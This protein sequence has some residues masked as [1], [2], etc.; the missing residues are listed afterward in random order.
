[1]WVLSCLISLNISRPFAFIH[2]ETSVPTKWRL[3]NVRK[4]WTSEVLRN[5]EH[6]D[7][8]VRQIVPQKERPTGEVQIKIMFPF[9][10][11]RFMVTYSSFGTC[12][13][14]IVLM[15]CRHRN[16][17]YSTFKTCVPKKE[18]DLYLH[19]SSNMNSLTDCQI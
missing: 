16:T 14:E 12:T 15:L 9:R 19:F 18:H 8:T 7:L 10:N 6:L 2:F 4:Q 11:T 13:E 3:V 17:F 1:M 5:S